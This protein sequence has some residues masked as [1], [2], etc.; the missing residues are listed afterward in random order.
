MCLMKV[1]KR[2]LAADCTLKNKCGA[3]LWDFFRVYNICM[4]YIYMCYVCVFN[5][6]YVCKCIY[7]YE[8]MYIYN[9]YI[10]M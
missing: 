10:H 5:N 3:G 8:Y 1:L 9:I 4:L 2:Q 7:V 6:T